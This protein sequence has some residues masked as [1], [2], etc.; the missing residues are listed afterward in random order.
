VR[1]P[2]A[3]RL[4]TLLAAMVLGLVAVVGRLAVLQVR[5]HRALAAE[6]LRQ[7]VHL[8][9]LPAERGRIVDRSGAPLAITL[10]AR[11]VYADPRYVTDPA[12]EAA[13]IARIL[14]LRRRPVERLLRGET[15][16]VYV[17]RQV[18][19]E[20][21]DRLAAKALPGIGFLE[22][23]KRSYPAGPLAPQVLGFV[24]VDA[25]GLAG[26]EY[27]YE[28]VLAGRPG[29]RSVELSADGLP[30]PAGIEVVE[31]AAPGR[32]L[33]TTLDRELQYLAQEAIR[34]AVRDNRAEA[35]TIVV[36]DP[37]TGDVYAMASA[38]WFDPNAFQRADRSAIRNRAVTDT[39]EPGSVNKVVTAAA[40]LESGA[41]GVREVFEVPWRMRV[42]GYTVHDSH[43]HA[44]EE[45][46]LADI[47]ARSSNIGSALV[48][49]R[50]GS[51]R[52][53]SVLSRFGYGRPT[54][55][56]F[57]GEVGGRLPERRS[58]TE[59]T[60]TTVSYGQGIS[61]TP[62]QM[63]AVYAT[64][65]NG[66]VWVRPRLVRGTVAPGG[67]FVA[68]PPTERR[69][70]VSEETASMLTRMLASVVETG[71]GGAAQ[72]P[73]YQVAGKTGTAR[74]LVD[75]RYVQRYMAS[76][77]G[78]LPASRPRVVIAVT[79]DEPE[80]V[81]GGVAAAPAFSE[82]ARHVIQRFA[83]PAAPPVPLPPR[84]SER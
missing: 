59:V 64:V 36:M 37:R 79:L 84:A 32:T 54:G 41:V 76:F 65:A 22:V 20:V 56:G 9:E 81:Y 62:L 18:D 24:G 68:A 27:E 14:D 45:M 60:R 29:T 30:I 11:D 52:L 42:G 17:A 15:S 53:A 26:L 7:R 80:T 12:R 44:L 63:A 58:W 39:L 75:G 43:P 61:M 25:T 34:R 21:A 4:L 50:V 28:E 10:D 71:T 51:G 16:F 83:I 6:G 73:G 33:V 40:A 47:V 72:I 48:A 8:L 31:P 46:T 55:V 1:R 49:E 57:P 67:R 5:D 3:G 19:E 74:K 23:P 77:V 13:T 70:V 2:P 82:V 66:G 69:R 78:F 38:P 35:G